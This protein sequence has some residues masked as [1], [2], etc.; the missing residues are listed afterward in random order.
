MIL[1]LQRLRIKRF[2]ETG[3]RREVECHF[4]SIVV[5]DKEV[6]RALEIE[7]FQPAS[8]EKSER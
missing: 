4:G 1:E 6:E 3:E 8:L 5:C 7:L 2:G